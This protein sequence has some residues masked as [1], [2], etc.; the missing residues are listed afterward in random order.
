[1]IFNITIWVV[2]FNATKKGEMSA[3]T[4]I[5]KRR[6][7]GNGQK[8]QLENLY[9]KFVFQ[10]LFVMIILDYEFFGKLIV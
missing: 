9:L 4:L 5:L 6:F 3:F 8:N 7:S 1:M 2:A 10:F